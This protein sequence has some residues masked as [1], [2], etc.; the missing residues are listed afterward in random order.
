M[1]LR[2]DKEFFFFFLKSY[3]S[4]NTVVWLLDGAVIASVCADKIGQEW[5]DV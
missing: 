3:R 5:R 4:V 2:V 1:L